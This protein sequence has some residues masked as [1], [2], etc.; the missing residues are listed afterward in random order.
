MSGR[1][2]ARR[3]DVL[4]VRRAAAPEGEFATLAY[5]RW[6]SDV[7]TSLRRPLITLFDTYLTNL[8][9]ALV[10][11]STDNGYSIHHSFDE[12]SAHLHFK[13]T[14]RVLSN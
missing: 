2:A 1:D 12:F 5:S 13:R 7:V 10:T 14:L 3:S 9:N 11:S 6:S 4:C 8:F